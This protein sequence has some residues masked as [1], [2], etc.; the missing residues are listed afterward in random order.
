MF[1]LLNSHQGSGCVGFL[2]IGSLI[3]PGTMWDRFSSIL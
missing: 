2:N 1:K 3:L